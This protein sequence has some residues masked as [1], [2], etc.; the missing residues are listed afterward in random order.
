LAI[1]P[2]ATTL[3]LLR[4]FELGNINDYIPNTVNDAIGYWHYILTFSEVG[5]N[6]G[7]YSPDEATAAI[8]LFRFDV[9]G[10][11][12]PII[13]GSIAAIT[14]WYPASGIWFNVGFLGAALVIFT[15]LARLTRWQILMTAL[16][17]VTFWPLLLYIPTIRQESF[18]QAMA[19]VLAGIVARLI[20]GGGRVAI[21]WQVAL[22]LFVFFLA[23][24]RFSWALLYPPLI[25]LMW[26]PLNWK[27]VGLAFVVSAVLT[28][29]VLVVFRLITPPGFNTILDTVAG[30]WSS[31]DEGWRG[32]TTFFQ[33]NWDQLQVIMS[34]D[35]GWNI[36]SLQWLHIILILVVSL[37]IL[38]RSLILKMP[39]GAGYEAL[40]HGFNLGLSTLVVLPLYEADNYFRFF[41]V[42]LLLSVMVMLANRRWI[43]PAVMIVSSLL[44]WNSFATQYRWW[45]NDFNVDRVQLEQQR[46]ELAAYVVYDPA[47]PSGWCNTLYMPFQLYDGRINAIP[48]GIGVN[49]RWTPANQRHPMRSKYLLFD[50]RVDFNTFEQMRASLRVERLAQ[51]SIGDLYLNLDADCP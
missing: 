28:L 38:L 39:A 20:Q 14:G 29:V 22:M 44:F 34:I 37:T 46:R 49:W 5:L 23:L 19:I 11:M 3:L 7:Y 2:T 25:L 36:Q 50:S 33:R 42:P 18:H 21:R 41:G 4:V 15:L 9:H 48:A 8:S 32:L 30:F 13:Y 10:P 12:F 51:L 26:R 45:M 40:F 6:G 31:F 35:N 17:V 47:A 1:L 43:I 16:V 27:R 24:V